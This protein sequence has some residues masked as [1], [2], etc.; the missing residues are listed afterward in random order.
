MLWAEPWRH[1]CESSETCWLL[2][3]VGARVGAIRL[4]GGGVEGLR[5]RRGTGKKTG[6]W[7]VWT[8]R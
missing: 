8:R 7:G 2:M 3:G 5:A 1:V 4:A 6:R